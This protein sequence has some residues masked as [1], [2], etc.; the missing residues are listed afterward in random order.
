M[1]PK[2]NRIQ[3]KD[4]HPNQISKGKII[5][6]K[7][8]GIKVT[9]SEKTLPPRF[10]V[11]ISKKIDKRAVVRNKT[12]RRIYHAA[13]NLTGHMKKGTQT[14][15]LVKK[16]ATTASLPELQDSIHNAL[17]RSKVIKEKSD[18]RLI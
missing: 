14:V 6:E 8:F 9:K 10:L 5:Q 4:I 11:I 15:F 7:F 2:T 3:K 12:K 1:L 18:K 16:P 13:Q 17:K